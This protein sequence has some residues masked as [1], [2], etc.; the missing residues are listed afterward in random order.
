MDERQEIKKVQNKAARWFSDYMKRAT[1][2]LSSD[3]ARRQIIKASLSVFR[4]TMRND[5][6]LFCR[7]RDFCAVKRTV[8]EKERFFDRVM[9]LLK[10][11][12]RAEVRSKS[13]EG[14]QADEEN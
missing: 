14:K 7:V 13:P 11:Q 5:E 9:G 1:S 10:E 8:G 6:A 3:E 12:I 2:S 4:R